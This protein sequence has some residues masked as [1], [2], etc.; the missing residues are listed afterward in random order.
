MILTVVRH[1]EPLPVVGAADPLTDLDR[2]LSRE[3]AAQGDALLRNVRAACPDDA[4]WGRAYGAG[5]VSPYA[6]CRQTAALIADAVDHGARWYEVPE[7]RESA[8]A[9]QVSRLRTKMLVNEESSFELRDRVAR[10]MSMVHESTYPVLVVTHGDVVNAFR[11]VVEGRTL[12]QYRA[13]YD[14]PDNYVPFG[15]AW[16]FDTVARTAERRLLRDTSPDK[17]VGIRNTFA[18][19]ADSYRIV[20]ARL[21][22]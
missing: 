17:M 11:W 22:E 3:G 14:D 7:L 9:A 18:H 13:L 16:T 10:L 20:P 21:G 6:R 12:A 5:Y 15:V 19:G 2:P 4:P 8:H 1:L